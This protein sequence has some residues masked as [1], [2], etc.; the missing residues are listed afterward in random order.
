MAYDPEARE[1]SNTAMIIGIIALVVVVGAAIAYF[2]NRPA[3]TPV[4]VVPPTEHTTVVNNTVEVPVD[5]AP[6]P[7]AVIVNPPAPATNTTTR[8]ERNTT[9]TKIIAPPRQP[10]G[11]APAPRSAPSGNTNVNVDVHVPA[12]SGG[13]TGG[14]S[15][16]TSGT[17]TTTGTDTDAGAGAAT[18]SAKGY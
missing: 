15:S 18:N 17:N 2:A 14:T 7:P 8:I 10:A 9:N 11:V 4:A 1:S 5:A 6:A 16:T 13:T 12:T 3:D